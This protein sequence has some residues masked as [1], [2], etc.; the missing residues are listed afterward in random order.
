MNWRALIFATVS[1]A[2]SFAA[3]GL[4]GGLAPIFTDLYQ[5]IR[6]PDRAARR[7]PSAAGIGGAAADGHAHRSVWRTRHVHA[8][9]RR[10][11]RRPRGLVPLTTSYASLLAAAFFIGLAGSSFSIG[12]AFVSRWTPP[13]EQG[14]ALGIFGLGCSASRSRCSAG[15]WRPAPSAGRRVFRGVAVVLLVSGGR[16]RGRSR[17]TTRRAA[18]PAS[19][20]AM[21]RVLR[22]EPTA[23]WLGAFYFL[24]FGGFVAFSI[25]L[26]T[27]LRS[28]FRSDAGRC[29]ISCGRV[30][31][32][33]HVGAAARRLAGRSHWRRASPVVG[34][35]RRR[36]VLA[37]ARVAV[38]DPVHGGGARLRGAAR[39]RQRRRVQA[40]ARALPSRH[41]H[42]HRPG[43]RARRP[44]RFLPATA[45]RLLSRLVRR[46]VAGVCAV[47]V[48]GA[49]AA[50][51]QPAR[52]SP[53]DAAW[54]F[55]L[56][57]H[58]RQAVD[59][60]RAGAWAALWTAGLAAA[61]V[62]GS[63]NLAHFD[64]ALVGY[65]FATLFA[66]FGIT[67]RYAMWLRS[68]ADANVLAA[69]LGRLLHPI[70]VR[71]ATSWR[72]AGARRSTWRRIVSSSAAAGCVASR[73]G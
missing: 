71:C 60:V 54:H 63:R 43:R 45:A 48:D 26:P 6:V 11:R 53:A 52:L 57:P 58:S 49:R 31:G 9:A 5:L 50:R 62:V 37:A 13:A 72:W 42:G 61:I 35:Q 8:A 10:C 33:G 40:R 1:F 51:R 25:Y 7:G 59:R 67:Y 4:V 70:V 29:R 30:R 44:R 20:A 22:H 32:A 55:A 17:A 41:R 23:W 18:R 3:W 69:R 19:V 12:A 56:P 47:V 73:T 14:T 36:A 27:L 28:Q 65:T 34:V 2:L 66:V 15:R 21:L 46:V 16:V 64:A 24:T 39:A 38:D 68:A